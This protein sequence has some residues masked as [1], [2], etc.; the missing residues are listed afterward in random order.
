MWNYFL[1]EEK[2]ECIAVLTINRPET[3]NA[4]S[5][6]VLDE[7]DA[8]IDDISKKDYLRAL[9][10]TGAGRAFVAGADLVIQSKFNYD[11]AFAW[12]QK[13][14]RIFQ[15]IE[16][17]GIPVIA[18]V[19]GFALGGGCELAL[20]CDIIIASDKAK[21]GQPEV[22]L[23]VTPGFAGTQRLTRKIGSFKAKELI[24][25]AVHITAEEAKSIGLVNK[26]VPH[27]ELLDAALEMALLIA[28]KAPVAVRNSIEAINNA[29]NMSQADGI[30][31]EHR[32]FASCFNTEDLSIGMNAFFN[33]EKPKFKNK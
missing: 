13:G 18:A 29:V 23:G 1:Y 25:T 8:I 27:E 6:D 33:K 4:L 3:L 2:N 14:C 30:K 20:A 28:S 7:L 16:D 15:K 9:I 17:L 19:N 5:G 22:N 31:E 11:E 12:S 24:L 21:F 32:L 10:L 26:V